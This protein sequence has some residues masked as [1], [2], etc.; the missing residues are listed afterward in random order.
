[1]SLLIPAGRYT[2]TDGTCKSSFLGLTAS[3]PLLSQIASTPASSI[4]WPQRSKIYLQAALTL[5]PVVIY[6]NVS[7]DEWRQAE[8]WRRYA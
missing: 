4:R 5:R 2:A 3:N 7:H 8:V 1:M 6:L